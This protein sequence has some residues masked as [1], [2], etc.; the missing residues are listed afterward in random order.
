ML[1]LGVAFGM[2]T[3]RCS[4]LA[5]CEEAAGLDEGTQL[6]DEWSAFGGGARSVVKRKP[7]RAVNGRQSLNS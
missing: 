4:D 2:I 3:Q 7:I 6:L 5:L 1:I